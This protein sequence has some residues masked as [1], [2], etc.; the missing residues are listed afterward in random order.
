MMNDLGN[1]ALDYALKNVDQAEIYL[2]ITENVDATIQNDQVDFAKEAYSMGIG[3]RVI[4]DNRMGFAY[5]TKRTDYWTVIR[6]FPML[7][8]PCL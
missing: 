2:E 7:S 1:Q 6:Q 8:K 3:I 4:N 5:T